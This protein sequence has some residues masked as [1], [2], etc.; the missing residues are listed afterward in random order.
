MTAP[1]RCGFA[2]VVGRPNVGKST[3]INRL[4]G[5]KISITTPRPQTTRHRILGIRTDRASQIVFVDT[6]GIHSAGGRALNRAMNRTARHSLGE[7]DVALWLTEAGRFGAEDAAVL[8]L[9]ALADKPVFALL[10]KIDRIKP[11]EKLLQLLAEMGQRGEFAEMVPISARDGSNV[12]RLL[13]CL[14]NYLPESPPLYGEDA[15][16]DRPERFLVSEIIREKLTMRLNKE[17]PYGLT[18]TID[19]YDEP[20]EPGRPVVIAAAIIV[21]R[22]T[23]KPI[24]IGK[25]GDVLKA[26]GTAARSDIERMLGRPVHLDLWVRVRANWSD[27]D[28][29]LAKLGFD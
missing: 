2:A 13:E 20:P 1:F 18:V 17:I 10:N 27:S 9:L 11:K 29:E 21:D 4:V 15:V 8:K 16:T 22:A 24:T 7:C 19:S 25:G 26:V 5:Q 23:Q 28:I 6:P 14:P 3:L 12:D